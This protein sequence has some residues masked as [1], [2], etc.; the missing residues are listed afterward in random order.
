MKL[1]VGL[2]NTGKTYQGTRHNIGRE[3]VEQT[4][5]F[6]QA[7]PFRTDKKL[8]ALVSEVGLGDEKILFILPETFMNNSGEAVQ[9]AA[10]YFDIEPGDILVVQDEMDFEPFDF[11]FAKGG[12]AGGHNGI[13]S[14]YS[15]VSDEVHRFRI[16]IGRPSN[17]S[18]PSDKYVLQK[19]G[20]VE[21]MKLAFVKGKI[22]DA[23]SDWMTEGLEQAMNNW[24]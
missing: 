13:K 4:A 2:G 18:L 20:A 16:G 23:I 17:K 1:I 24:N 9:A 22:I 7:G 3:M 12:G 19:F 11:A 8:K 6:H 15:H 5:L 10:S 21:K 14:I